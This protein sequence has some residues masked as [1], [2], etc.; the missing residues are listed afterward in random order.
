MNISILSNI[1]S[2]IF[3]ALKEKKL[4][5]VYPYSKP[6]LPFLRFL[7]K[8]RLIRTL[9]IILYENKLCFKIFLL[10]D[11]KKRPFFINLKIFSKPKFWTRLSNYKIV[12]LDFKNKSSLFVFLTSKGFVTQKTLLKN[13]IGGILLYK[14]N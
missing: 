14:I 2:N 6:L 5:I 4:F 11:E 1:L 10:Y 7:I 12:S 9:K 3:L 13:N 8:Y